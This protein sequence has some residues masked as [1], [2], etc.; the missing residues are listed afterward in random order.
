[1]PNLEKEHQYCI[2]CGNDELIPLERYHAA[3]LCQCLKCDLVFSDQKP[4]NEQIETLQKRIKWKDHITPEAFKRYK[5]IL[6]R[7]EHFRKNNRILDIDCSH[8]EFLEMAK[9]RG[10][11]VV[12]TADTKESLEIC[13]SKGLE[14]YEGS[15]NLEAFPEDSFDIVCARNVIEH[16]LMPNE[17]VQK[18]RRIL[19]SGGLL[20]VT[21]PN[22]N[23]F[24]RYRLK[25]KYSVISYPL[26]LVYYSRSTFKKLFRQNDFKILE[27]EATG[28]SISKRRVVKAQIQAPMTEESDFIDRNGQENWFVRFQKRN[29]SPVFSFFGIG[30]FLKGWFIKP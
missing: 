17:D 10:W 16:S 18:M 4:S 6:D 30:D 12:G 25:E 5:H 8:G 26:R 28:V 21:T 7:F 24:L 3:H 27:T 23:S 2:L 20:Y 9:E 15:L 19:R 1:M 29:L 13:R 14:M 11:E 22:F